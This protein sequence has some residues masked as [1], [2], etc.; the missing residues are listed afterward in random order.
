[1]AKFKK[2]DR[3]IDDYLGAGAVESE[4]RSG[5]ASGMVIGYMVLFDKTP[6]VRYNMARNP[7]IVFAGTL[8]AE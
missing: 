1:M 3:V 6:D 7:T 5:L 2:G 4:I 8:K